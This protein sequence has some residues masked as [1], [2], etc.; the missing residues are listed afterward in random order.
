MCP[1]CWATLLA[2]YG[3]LLAISA[4]AIAGRDRLALPLAAALGVMGWVHSPGVTPVPWWAFAGVGV[5]LVARVA[6]LVIRCRRELLV[7]RAWR[8]A[9]AFASARCPVK[10][11]RNTRPPASASR[12]AQAVGASP[13]RLTQGR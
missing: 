13:D 8:V 9:G 10:P 4:V 2:T 5:A 3:A 12:A 1:M 6:Y 7:A 11:C